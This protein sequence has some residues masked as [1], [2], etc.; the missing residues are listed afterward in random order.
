[1]GYMSPGRSTLNG[2]DARR[3]AAGLRPP[4]DV[5]SGT[6]P[7]PPARRSET[8]PA[9][10]PQFLADIRERVQSART[11][12]VLAVNTKLIELYWEIGNEILGREDREGWGARVIDRLAADLR[13]EFPDMKGLSRSN[14]K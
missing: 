12:A 11:Q 1:M 5:A 6:W 10:Y 13:R 7:R 4:R 9:D 3:R 2:R 8:L 14:L